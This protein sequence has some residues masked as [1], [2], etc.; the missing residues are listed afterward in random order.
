MIKYVKLKAP[1]P[2]LIHIRHLFSICLKLTWAFIEFSVFI[3]NKKALKKKREDE[4]TST[5]IWILPENKLCLLPTEKSESL[6]K[7]KTENKY[8]SLSRSHKITLVPT[9]MFPQRSFTFS[10]SHFS[11]KWQEKKTSFVIRYKLMSY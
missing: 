2:A 6:R 8:L 11:F 4:T 10:N 3:E 1:T 9:A 7:I 5:N